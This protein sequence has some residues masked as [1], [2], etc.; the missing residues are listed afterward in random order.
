[1]KNRQF[2]NL[3]NSKNKKNCISTP[4]NKETNNNKNSKKK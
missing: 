4:V 3:K 2:N 1:M